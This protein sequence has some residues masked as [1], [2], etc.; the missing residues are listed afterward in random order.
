MT[1]QTPAAAESRAHGKV[2]RLIGILIS[3]G[4]VIGGPAWY[5]WEDNRPALHKYAV[6]LEKYR[7]RLTGLT[8]T[9]CVRL[10]YR[11]KFASDLIWPKDS[12][13]C[14]W[15]RVTGGDGWMVGGQVRRLRGDTDDTLLYGIVPAVATEVVL[16]PEGGT[17]IRIATEVVDGA[18]ANRIYAHLQ[19][20]L[21]DQVAIAGVQ[22][23]DAQG[24]EV[25]VY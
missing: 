12:I 8:G 15:P 21:G 22:L 18:G 19:S 24:G 9:K 5:L 1:A 4:I 7:L 6:G 10:E 11:S 3:I 14:A 17:P 23:R 25:R 20:G 16:T 13:D 2:R